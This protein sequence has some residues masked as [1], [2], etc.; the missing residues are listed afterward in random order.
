MIPGNLH[1]FRVLD[2]ADEPGLLA[3]RLLG[4]LGADV[5][6]VEPPG[7][8]PLRRRGPFWNGI[9]DAE[10]SLAWLAQNTSKRGITLDLEQARGR[11]LFLDLCEHADA[12]LETRAPG[13][14]A[15]RGIGYDAQRGRN[16]RIVLCSITPF[17]QSGPW[18]DWR[19][20]DLT[21][22]ATGGNLFPTGDADRA[23]VRASLPTSYFHAGIEAALAVALAWIARGPTG[24]GQHVDVSL[25]EVMLMPNMSNPA[26]YGLTK[27]K[28]GRMGPGYRVGKVFQPE[29]W[30]CQD[31]FV[32]FALRGGAA[33]IPGL[34]A[35]V[36]Y[37]DESGMAPP[38]LKDRNW[39]SY[40]HNLLRQA[41]VD[42]M[43]AAFEP[44]FASKTKAELYRA[45][46]DRKLMLAPVNDPPAILASEQLAAR[47][48]FVDVDYPHLGGQLRHPGAV[49][50]LK[51][52]GLGLRSRAPRIGEHNAEVFAELGLG[53]AELAALA[54][55][56]VI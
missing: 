48:F 15:E 51:P 53:T 46:L 7:G 3:G 25:Q 26:Q 45:A 11:E 18:R 38:I 16:P 1:G 37:M 31:G 21:A 36:Q 5:V 49:A 33:R 34:I 56:R 42:E 9:A 24:A 52:G 41:E 43:K 6:Q 27:A 54:R 17:G 2:L 4:D 44:F 40:N 10:R 20:S 14:L 12:V 55:E 35:M 39:K 8:H 29:I 50:C 28:G 23:P 30:R 19:A 22:L 32:S 47:E 13:V